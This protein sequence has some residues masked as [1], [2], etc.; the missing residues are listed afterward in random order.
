MSLFF[1]SYRSAARG[2]KFVPLNNQGFDLFSDYFVDDLFLLPCYGHVSAN[3]LPFI[4]EI[5]FNLWKEAYRIKKLFLKFS[6]NCKNFQ[7][8]FEI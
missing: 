1:D 7:F 6:K 2:S 8:F 4:F 5:V 3:E